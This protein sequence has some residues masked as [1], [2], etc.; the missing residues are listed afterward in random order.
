MASGDDGGRKIIGIYEQTTQRRYGKPVWEAKNGNYNKKNYIYAT[1]SGFWHISGQNDFYANS[2]N[3]VARA[4]LSQ[5]K[6]CPA[7]LVYSMRQNN[8]WTPSYSLHV[9]SYEGQSKV[10]VRS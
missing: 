1:K 7:D 8:N 2:E 3:A 6:P 10:V 9:R 5:V 4:D